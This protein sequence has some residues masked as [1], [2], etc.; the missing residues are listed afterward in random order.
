VSTAFQHHHISSTTEQRGR[1]K[2]FDVFEKSKIMA[3]HFEKV[4]AKE[5]AARLNWNVSV[6]FKIILENKDLPITATPTPPKKRSGHP[7]HHTHV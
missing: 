7:R 2:H 4:P 1:G 5:I 3:W 6:V